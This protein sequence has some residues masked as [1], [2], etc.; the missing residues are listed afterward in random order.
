MINSHKDSIELDVGSVWMDICVY[1][2]KVPLA[3]YLYIL[4]YL[5]TFFAEDNKTI[6]HHL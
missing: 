4:L 1:F 2:N 5:Y 3:V 6:Y